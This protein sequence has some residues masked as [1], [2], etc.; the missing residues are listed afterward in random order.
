MT[1]ETERLILRPW[2]ECDAAELYKYASDPRVADPTGFLPHKSVEDSR[3]II[4]NVLSMPDCYAVVLK[5]TGKPVGC[6][7][8]MDRHHTVDGIE[9]DDKEIGYWLGVPYWGRGLIPEAVHELLRR[10]FYELDCD[11]VWCGYYDGNAKS[12]R[13]QEKCGF[14][15]RYTEYEKYNSQ[16]GKYNTIHISAVIK[17][18][19]E[20]KFVNN[21]HNT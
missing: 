15:Y 19:W 8:I 21:S 7:S 13:V 10:C 4:K 18:D 3:D 17:E 11:D 5:L 1:L 20:Q 12:K 9:R 6:I 16:T 2:N 14:E